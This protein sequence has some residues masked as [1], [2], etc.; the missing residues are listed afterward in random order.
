MAK[1]RRYRRKAKSYHKKARR[2]I[3][4][5]VVIAGGA[6]PFTPARDGYGRTPFQAI[7]GGDFEYAM[8]SL[9]DGFTP[10]AHDGRMDVWNYIN[11]FNLNGGR[12][13]KMLLYAGLASKVRKKF[14]KIPFNKVPIIGKYIS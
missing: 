4:F 2:T 7:Q 14:V 6:I 3:P 11:P 10:I 12:Y 5:E 13:M 8:R 9:M 1:K